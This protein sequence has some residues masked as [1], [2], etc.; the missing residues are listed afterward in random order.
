MKKRGAIVREIKFRAWDNTSKKMIYDSSFSSSHKIM[1]WH[2]T[3]Y[4]NGKVQDYVM[5]QYTGLRDKNNVEI[6]EGDIWKR[7]TFIARVGFGFSGWALWCMAESS[8][9]YQ[10]PSFYSN[11]VTGEVIG[12][13][14]E[15]PEL[16]KS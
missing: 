5:L 2:G 9:C 11:A 12:N 16:I 15:N 14:Y 4:N 13:I 1:T 7:E 6:Y 8:G 10:Y 3:V